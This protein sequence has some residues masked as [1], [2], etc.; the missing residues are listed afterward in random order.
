MPLLGSNVVDVFGFWG[1]SNA[2]GDGADV[3]QL[4]AN[5]QPI[6][7]AIR[8]WNGSQWTPLWNGHNN[9]AA[10]GSNLSNWGPEA[11]FTRQYR[12]AFPGREVYVIKKA[13]GGSGLYVPFNQVDWN[14]HSTNE[15]YAQFATMI[16]NAMTAL[17]GLGR[18]GKMRAI[19]SAIGGWETDDAT[20]AASVEQN[21]K[22][23][24][25]GT[26]PDWAADTNTIYVC[27]KPSDVAT[28]TSV[29]DAGFDDL[30]ATT[31]KVFAFDTSTY[32]TGDGIHFTAAGQVSHGADGFAQF[33]AHRR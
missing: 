16:G 23:L 1:L 20:A 27:A 2:R 8:I 32:P 33:L 6:D 13:H 9:N 31:P 12:L 3:A 21:M 28:Y 4:P 5:L 14:I 24:V 7:P 29:V 10:V 15:Y 17:S 19:V 22:D 18:I 11:E 26:N 25:A 30:A